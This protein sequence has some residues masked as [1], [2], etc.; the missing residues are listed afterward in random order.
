MSIKSQDAAESIW[1][2][3]E[4][5]FFFFSLGLLQE[6]G[7]SVWFCEAQSTEASHDNKVCCCQPSLFYKVKE[8]LIFLFY[9]CSYRFIL[10]IQTPKLKGKKNLNKK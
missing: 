10:Q 1:Q 5:F 4:T 6:T 9:P 7:S 8:T 2:K 3:L